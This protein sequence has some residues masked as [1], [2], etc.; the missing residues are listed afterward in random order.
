MDL[1]RTELLL[2]NKNMEKLKTAHIAVFGIGGVGGYVAEALARSGI[3]RLD[4]IDN[5]IISESNINRQIIALCST[6]GRHKTEVMKERIKDINPE[7]EVTE[8]RCFFLPE[9]QADFDFAKYNYIVDAVDTVTAKIELVLAARR[10]KIPVISSMGTG[11]KLGPSRFRVADIYQTSV[12]PLAK[13]MRKELKK[14]GVEKLKTVFS[15]EEPKKYAE[16]G[17]CINLMSD[18]SEKTLKRSIPG[19]LAY[20]P[21]VAGLMMASEVIK[22]ILNLKY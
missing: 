18:N 8:Y 16:S 19:S 22:D 1:I 3:G 11:N 20:V 21:S 5:D 15:D 14:K 13:V 17:L 4:L 12:C 10:A 7:C 6:I 2:G 9:N